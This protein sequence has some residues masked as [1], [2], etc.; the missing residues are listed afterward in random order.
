[1]LSLSCKIAKGKAEEAAAG[2]GSCRSRVHRIHQLKQQSQTQ[3][4]TFKEEQTITTRCACV[5]LLIQSQLQARPPHLS[6]HDL[7]LLHLQLLL[8][9]SPDEIPPDLAPQFNSAFGRGL[10]SQWGAWFFNVLDQDD[11][12]GAWDILKLDKSGE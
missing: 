10:D 4:F 8:I 1:M 9:F 11:A 7:H 5:A 2:A 3:T 12:P 6:R